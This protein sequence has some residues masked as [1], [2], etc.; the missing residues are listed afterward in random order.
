MACE[1]IT[2]TRC[3][4]SVWGVPVKTDV[5]R[6]LEQ[7]RIAAHAAGGPVAYIT[8]VPVDA[9]PPNAEVRKYLDTAMP[10]IVSLCSTYHVVLEGAG[11]VAAVKR[12]VLVSLFQVRWRNGTF[13]VHASAGEV[14]KA[15]P[16][17]DRPNVEA[18]LQRAQLKGLLSGMPEKSWVEATPRV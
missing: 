9:P 15:V 5:D 4:F 11:F 8:R 2:G 6:L 13:F 1:I 10:T 16:T 14:L 12:A 3:L 18:L 17:A 7:L